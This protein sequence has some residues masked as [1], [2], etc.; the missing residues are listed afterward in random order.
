MTRLLLVLALVGCES[1]HDEQPIPY[2][3]AASDAPFGSS[4]TGDCATTN[5]RA[6]FMTIRF[7]DRAFFGITAAD[8]TLHI[9]AYRGG[10]A[11]CPTMTSPTPEYALIL[12][13]VPRPTS[14]MPST[15]PATLLD[16]EGDLLGG[17]LGA[18]ATSVTLSP[19]AAM[20]DTFVAFEATL[21]FPEA[22]VRGHFYATHC[23]SMDAP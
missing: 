5:L 8:D 2:P 7:L 15:S 3:D 6:Q 22:E 14:S 10:D 11:S 16:Y 19:V 12:G 13:R 4:C 21:D 20:G 1:G 17:A 23:E 18:E 9:E